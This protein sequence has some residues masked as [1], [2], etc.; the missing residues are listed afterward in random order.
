ML[1]ESD[2]GWRFCRLTALAFDLPHSVI[3]VLVHPLL[4]P[5][6]EL[7]A[8]NQVDRG[9][10]AIS[11]IACTASCLR[12]LPKRQRLF[13][14]R[15]VA[16]RH[17]S[18]NVRLHREP[19]PSQLLRFAL[20]ET[21]QS[22]R[23]RTAGPYLDQHLQDIFHGEWPL[24][25]PPPSWSLLQSGATARN[26]E[27]LLKGLRQ[28]VQNLQQLHALA[29]KNVTD[30]ETA[31]VLQSSDCMLLSRALERCQRY[32]LRTD[33]LSALNGIIARLKILNLPV[34]RHIHVLGMKYACL[35]HSAPA[36][37]RHLEGYCSASPKTLD[38]QSS[39]SLV[40][41]LLSFIESVQFD[42]PGYD[43]NGILSLVTGESGSAL[44]SQ[45]R[46]H[47]ILCW[48]HPEGT[49]DS[50]GQYA[51][52][53]IR[54][55][56][57]G[58]LQ[59]TWDQ[60]LHSLFPQSPPSAFH[61][62]Y[63]CVLALI[64]FGESERAVNCLKDLSRRANNTLPGISNYQRLSALLADQTVNETL[65]PLAGQNEFLGI[66]GNQLTTIEDR[67]GIKWQP[68]ESLHSHIS[69]PLCTVSGQALFSIDGDSNG[70][71]SEDRLIAEINALGCSKSPA[72]LG[73]I[74]NLLDEHEGNEIPVSLSA[75][76]DLPYE[77]AWLPRRSPI[78]FSATQF[79][80][81][82][83][84]DMSIP[85]S[86]HTLGLIRA[87]LV[88]DGV[89][90][91][92]DCSLH[93]MQLGS[94]VTKPVPQSDEMNH[95]KQHTW[96]PSGYII[97]LDRTSGQLLAVFLGKQ[98]GF[99]D[100]GILPLLSPLQ[101]GPG[102]VVGLTLPGDD[103]GDLEPGNRPFSFEDPSSWLH[104]EVDPSLDLNF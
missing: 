103:S 46:L 56:S 28:D 81:N 1:E 87:R 93:L 67:L 48:S 37:K 10:I 2:G 65:P 4:I 53:L 30:A 49:R 60:F 41:A 43:T 102:A 82:P 7:D 32:N 40:N 45:H 31:A 104:I 23:S 69:D 77:F 62:A 6:V 12:L 44:Q 22:P 89:G 33:I 94:L 92:N 38:L 21:T 85:W 98:H 11:M 42:N 29:E 86:P 16:I 72:D 97:A 3:V 100:P 79:P 84:T 55:Q 50:A 96:Q 51:L 99:L 66:L 70:F 14:Q 47:N 20:T 5:R 8:L 88:N 58:I 18:A 27:I 61:S 80:V 54:L 17:A 90:P 34:S 9:I 52:L 35:G 95:E 57:R 24:D 78:E 36:L 83:R 68:H 101:C 73:T 63:T 75:T 26:A 71:D 59:R 39:I 25:I 76:K 19:S 91:A 74:A 15:L 64:E 13:S